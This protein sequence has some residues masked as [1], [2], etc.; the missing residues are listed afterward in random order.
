MAD[1]VGKKSNIKTVA[2]AAVVLLVAAVAL[3]FLI[4]ADQFRPQIESR[5]SAELGRDVRLGKLRMS[6]FSGRLSVDDIFIM[7]NPEFGES[8]FVTAR[9]FYIGVRLR[10]LIFSKKIHITEISLEQPSIYLRRSSKGE[11]NISGLGAGNGGEAE[12]SAGKSGQMAD[13]RVERL[14]I[15]DG[16]I[17]IIQSG[18][19]TSAFEKV[20]LSVD[21][22][23]RGAAFPFMFTAAFE[24][25]GKF[26]LQ[27][28]F[29]PLNQ[30]D[31][32]MT[33]FQAAV[34][35]THL[36]S[37]ASGFIPTDAGFSGLFDFSGDL[38][39]DA[40]I[41]Q[42]KG[43]ASI[44]NLKLVAGGTPAEKP[45]SLDYNLRY[46]LINKTGTLADATVGFGQAAMRLYGNFDA[47]GDVANIKMTLKGSGIPVDEFQEFLPPLGLMLPKG[48]ALAGGTLDAE[49]ACEGFL[50]D[51][52]M[53]G[54]A[55]ITGTALTGFNLGDKIAPVASFAGLKSDMDTQIEKLS[56]SMRWTATEITINDIHLVVP[57]LGEISGNGTISPE[58]ELDLDMRIAVS[59]GVL[60]S[61]TKGKTIEAGFF[62]RGDASDPEFIPDYKDAAR[63]LMDVVLA[64]KEADA[65]PA[66]KLRDVLKGLLG[67]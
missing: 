22:L 60:T 28:T 6:L 43:K 23:S 20:N 67:K 42:S 34:E 45:V 27:G 44:A 15:T 57:A 24:G 39:S 18:K 40:N 38:N 36:D 53:D 65:G 56:V 5:L 61:L 55:E 7:D 2:A 32:L 11:W 9:A 12:A 21:D 29:G 52:V 66:N 35:I 41:A 19:K 13:I 48:A 31:T 16:R 63:V 47:G 64:G 51:P 62:V 14:R 54:S 3:P 50:N 10:P 25:D 4:D 58:Q 1:D 49:I 46:N 26:S 8:P 33:S 17:E 37:A 59:N 30:D